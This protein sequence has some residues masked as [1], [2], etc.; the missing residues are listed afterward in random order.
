MSRPEITLRSFAK[1][2]LG[3]EIC[4]LRDDGFHEVVSIM[5]AIDLYDSIYLSP[6][7]NIDVISGVEGLE[8]SDDLMLQAANALRLATGTKMGAKIR[9]TKHIPSSAGLG[10]GSSNGATVLLGLNQLWKTE[11]AYPELAAISAELGSD[12]TFFLTGGTALTTGRGEQV[13]PQLPTPNSWVLLAKPTHG[14]STKK[15]YNCLRTTEYSKGSKTRS[16]M[17]SIINK[18]PDYSLMVNSLSSPA[19]RLLPEL[20]KTLSILANTSQN[21]L[22][23]GSGSTCFALF[24]SMKEAQLAENHLSNTGL[25]THICPFVGEWSNTYNRGRS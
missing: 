10:G 19:T 1:I 8:A 9:T 12:V 22:V 14:L 20:N 16:L 7:D 4:S 17:R 25:W 24:Q 5:Q 6:A 3:L 18:E 21:T 11:L 23:S 13:G 2:N 15:V